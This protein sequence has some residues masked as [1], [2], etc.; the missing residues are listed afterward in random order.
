MDVDVYDSLTGQVVLVTGASRGIGSVVAARLADRG[1]TVYGGARDLSDV[2]A[3]NLR[4]LELDVTDDASVDAAVNQIE[5]EAGRLDALVNNAGIGG[6]DE[7][8]HEADVDDIDATLA[9]NLRG[10]TVL[11]RRAIPLLLDGA[12]GRIVNV[13]SGM[14]A[15]SQ[16]MSGGSPAYRISKTG[17]NGLTAYLHGEY[18]D[19]SLL[20]NAV[21]PG[22][23]RTD[24]GGPSAPRS[25]DDGADTPAW[26]ARFRPGSPGGRFWR[27]REPIPW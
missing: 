24:M 20:A 12:G 26:L 1:A 18:A 8:L 22:W 13:S 4:P 10:P 14:G 21:C 16:G 17:L 5:R 23:V 7:P 2:S 15:L 25:P 27:D 19:G 11:A 9:T 6:P 3:D